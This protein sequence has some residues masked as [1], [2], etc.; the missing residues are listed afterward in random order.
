MSPRTNRTM[1]AGVLAGP[2]LSASSYT[3]HRPAQRN[4]TVKNTNFEV[5]T[6]KNTN[7]EV[8]CP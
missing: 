6:V 2:R 1:T 5:V 8:T 4:V 3:E 7:F